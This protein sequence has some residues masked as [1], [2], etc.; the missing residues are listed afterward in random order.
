M[1]F[2]FKSHLKPLSICFPSIAPSWSWTTRAG[3]LTQMKGV[4]YKTLK[5]FQLYFFPHLTIF[6]SVFQTTFPNGGSLWFCGGGRTNY[7][8]NTGTLFTPLC[9]HWFSHFL[10]R[11]PLHVVGQ[12]C[13]S[14]LSVMCQT[15]R[16]TDRQVN[17][18]NSCRSILNGC[19]FPKVAV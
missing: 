17:C 14:W 7:C 12:N 1:G 13:G 15:D 8:P 2:P 19:S 6:S 9:W 4:T 16:Q 5:T 11:S 10:V 18:G 3:L